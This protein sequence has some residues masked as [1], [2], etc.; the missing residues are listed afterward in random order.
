MRKF[1]FIVISL[2]LVILPGVALANVLPDVSIRVPEPGTILLLVSGL[3]GL[4]GFR[5]KFSK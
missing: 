5:R 4:W 2:A 1:S 3:L